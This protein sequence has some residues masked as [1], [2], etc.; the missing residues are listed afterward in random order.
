MAPSA[1]TAA[2][3]ASEP[4]LHNP[5]FKT[6]ALF[7]TPDPSPPLALTPLPSSYHYNDFDHRDKHRAASAASKEWQ[8][9]YLAFSRFCLSGQE[10]S[11]YVP[12]SKVLAAAGAVPLQHFTAPPRVPGK[13]P[14]YEL[15]QY[16]VGSCNSTWYAM[17]YH[18][19]PVAAGC[20]L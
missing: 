3:H 11:I 8:E 14:I 20:T 13:Q 6:Q 19:T 12:A 10:S 2:V 4:Q 17:Q 1:Q 18:G 16:Q 5:C 9:Q 15:R 7:M